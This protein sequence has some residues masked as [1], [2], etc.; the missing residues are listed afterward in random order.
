MFILIKDICDCT[1]PCGDRCD[2]VWMSVYFIM[3]LEF[4]F[5]SRLNSHIMWLKST[6]GI[7]SQVDE[8]LASDSLNIRAGASN[9]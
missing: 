7:Q 8:T 3:Y 4:P 5:F 9:D 1:C 2:K 6:K